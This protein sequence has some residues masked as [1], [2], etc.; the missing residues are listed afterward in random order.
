[1]LYFLILAGPSKHAPALLSPCEG[2]QFLFHEGRNEHVLDGEALTL[3]RFNEAA[4]K[5]ALNF[6]PARTPYRIVPHVQPAP[7]PAPAA[8]PA[9]AAR[10][11]IPRT[12][13][14]SAA[15]PEPATA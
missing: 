5:I 7:A 11:F 13:A 4:R 6:D 1:M 9:P 10:I 12:P 2:F 14:K 3:E 8:E 15:Q